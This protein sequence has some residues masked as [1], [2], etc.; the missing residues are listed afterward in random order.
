[1]F[2]DA[3]DDKT[4][5]GGR[6]REGRRHY[7]GPIRADSHAGAADGR[8]CALNLEGPGELVHDVAEV[9]IVVL[10]RGGRL[11]VDGHRKDLAA[12]VVASWAL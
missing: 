1:M 4:M 12:H 11:T 9:V 8:W 6:G 2:W 7:G 3:V 5:M 10:A